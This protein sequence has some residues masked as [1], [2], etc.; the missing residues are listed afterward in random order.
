MRL[1]VGE[2]AKRLWRKL[3]TLPVGLS[4]AGVQNLPPVWAT[5]SP[6]SNITCT[7]ASETTVVTTTNPLTATAGQGYFPIIIGN[8]TFLMGS[9][10]STALVIAARYHSGSD[11]SQTQTV[12]TGLLANSAT[13]NV[14][15]C[16]VGQAAICNT[17][18]QINAAALEVT[19]LATTNN[20]TCRSAASVLAIGLVA[21]GI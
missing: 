13:I 1:L 19:A 21:G 3:Q 17:S 14:P 2:Q 7:A 9:S 15:V 6:A 8:L 12:D 18:G 16:I 10:A 4:I 11:F 5:F 20:C